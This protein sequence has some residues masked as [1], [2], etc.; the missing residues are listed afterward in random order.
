MISILVG[1]DTQDTSK[2]NFDVH[3]D[4]LY[5]QSRFFREHFEQTETSDL[6]GSTDIS[7][8]DV[9]PLVFTQFMSWLYTGEYD[10]RVLGSHNGEVDQTAMWC[11][12]E[13]LGAP[14]FQNYCM[15]EI[16]AHRQA[17]GNWAGATYNATF[18]AT[19]V[20]YGSSVKD[21][22][23]RKFFAHILSFNKHSGH[24]T[25]V[26]EAED[27]RNWL[28]AI[29]D[30][31]LDLNFAPPT[32]DHDH[33]PWSEERAS[34]YLLWEQE[35]SKLWTDQIMSDGACLRSIVAK[36]ETGCAKSTIQWAHLRREGVQMREANV[37]TRYGT[38]DPECCSDY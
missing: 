2:Q 25:W 38:G 14:S 8:P 7:F 35:L 31:C 19:A 12:G 26:V 3:Q 16:M 5:L 11:L 33:P 23:I 1:R 32:L 6:P 15:R 20:A 27:W 29:P 22:R 18:E 9:E 30:L 17:S 28:T 24:G 37:C 36:F 34:T 21:S 13:K 10:E 4:M